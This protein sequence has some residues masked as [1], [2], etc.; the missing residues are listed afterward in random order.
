MH[1]I[2]DTFVYLR[3]C[4][5]QIYKKV[6][7]LLLVMSIAFVPACARGAATTDLNKV[8]PSAAAF[9]GWSVFEGP[10]SYTHDHLFDLVDGQSEAF[11]AYGFEQVT[12][13]RYQNAGG[14]RLEIQVWQVGTPADAY[15]LFTTSRAGTPAAVGNDGDTDPGQRII[16][17]QSHF[18]VQMFAD[19]PI[20]EAELSGFARAVSAALPS[21]GE[22]PAL[23]KRLPAGGASAKGPIFFHKEISFQDEIWLGAENILKLSQATNGVLGRYDLGGAE[24]RLLLI[25]YPT[26]AEAAAGLAAL[27]A[28]NVTDLAAS[29]AQNQLLGAVVGK[30]DPAA[31]SDLL[32]KGM[33]P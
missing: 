21:G 26:A 13:Q 32:K 16:F 17:W 27:Q 14:V 6:I 28:A 1:K 24:A 7:V 18:Y 22:R 9:P 5:T 20:P 11:F 8:F 3:C 31:A 10:I 12:V 2:R 19:Q 25:E 15:G 29:A 33:A 30:V 23:V 4:A